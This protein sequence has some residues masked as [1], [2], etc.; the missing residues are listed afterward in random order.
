MQ[1]PQRLLEVDRSRAWQPGA[2]QRRDQRGAP[3]AVGDDRVEAVAAGILLVDVG[4]VDIAR[5]HREQLDV[6]PA[7]RALEDGGLADLDLLERAILDH[8][9]CLGTHDSTVST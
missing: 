1:K 3:H 7:Q 2:E 5:H 8:R 9:C 4:G 6:P